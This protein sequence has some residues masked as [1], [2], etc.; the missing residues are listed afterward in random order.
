MSEMWWDVQAGTQ[1]L[2]LPIV[3]LSSDFAIC[4]LMTIDEPIATMQQCARELAA[5]LP[6]GIQ[7]VASAATLG[8]PIGAG[9][10]TALG[11]ERQYVLQKTPKKHLEDALLEPL[12]SLTTQGDQYLRLDARWIHHLKGKKVAFID[13]VIS[14]GGSCNAALKLLRAAGAEVVA[15]GV[16]LAEGDGWRS[17]LSPE[18][19]DNLHYLAPIPVFTLDDTSSTWKPKYRD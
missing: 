8:I 15:I 1:S 18:D 2:R 6:N 7:A 4:L 12:E 14:S 10:A 11:L 16:I 3:P 17:K 13:D 19:A 9:V 5:K